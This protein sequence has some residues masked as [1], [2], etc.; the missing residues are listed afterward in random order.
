ESSQGPKPRLPGGKAISPPASPP[1][2]ASWGMD[3]SWGQPSSPTPCSAEPLE[4]TVVWDPTETSTLLLPPRGPGGLG[5]AVN[6]IL[7][8]GKK[9]ERKKEQPVGSSERPGNEA[10]QMVSE[11]TGRTAGK[12]S[13]MKQLPAVTCCHP[14]PSS[15][16]PAASHTLPKSMAGSLLSSLPWRERARAEQARLLTLRGIMGTSSL[17]PTSEERNCPSNT[18]P[19]KC[20]WRKGG[21]GVATTGPLLEELY[22]RNPLVRDI[23]SEC[24]VASGD[25]HLP[26]P[27]AMCPHVSLGSVLSLEL[28]RD[29]V[30]LGNHQEVV[31]QQEEVEGQE[32]LQGSGVRAW[33]LTGTHR[34]RWHE[35][36]YVDGHSAWQRSKKLG[37]VSKC[38]KGMWSQ[39]AGLDPSD[40]QQR[41]HR[42][43]EEHC[44]PLIPGSAGE[45]LVDMRPR[46]LSR[47]CVLHRQ[48]SQDRDKLATHQDQGNSPV[49]PVRAT[50]HKAAPLGMGLSPVSTPSREGAI[51]VTAHTQPP[52]G[53]SQ[54]GE[55]SATAT[56]PT[57]LS[58]FE[59]ALGSP[60]TPSPAAA[61]GE[62]CPP[63]HGQFEEEEEELQAIWD[64]AGGGREPS[65]WEDSRTSCE[66]GSRTGSL[67]SPDAPPATSG[68]LILSSVN[69]VLVA[70]FTLPS[71]ARLLHSQSGEKSPSMGHSSCD[72]PAGGHRVSARGGK[73]VS[74]A[75]LDSPSA[76]D[77]QRNGEERESSKMSPGKIEFQRMEGMLERKHLLQAG[78]RK[79]SCRAWGL[80]HTVLMRQ[81]LCF[82][83]DHRD[84][85][86]SAVVALPLNLSQAVCTPDVEYT[87]KNN[88]FRLQLRDGSEYLLRAP[89]QPLMN[90]WVSKLQQNSGFPEVD[91]FQAAAQPV[92]STC[93][94]GRKVPS[95]SSIHLQGRHEVMATKS[96]E[97]VVLPYSNAQLQQPLGSQ[98]ALATKTVAA[99]GDCDTHRH[100]KQQWSPRGSPELWDKSCQDD[101]GLVA[102][103]RRSYSFTSATYQKITPVAVPKE[104]AEATGSYSVTLYIGEQVP[105]MPRARCHSFVAQ[106]GSQQNML[107]E[108]TSSPPRPKNKSVFKKFFG[109]E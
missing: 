41:P 99:A 47:V 108:K 15:R 44:S 52:A 48:V 91:Y 12:S 42:T 68:P 69:N 83:Q 24:E 17:Q 72:S 28:P 71:A 57:Q 87:K 25:H 45:D 26:D 77:R 104:P 38:E 84:S 46:Q 67:P 27:K 100:R 2:D 98:D 54:P 51:A 89:S 76:W 105:A 18:W 8:I 60:D 29:T 39:E 6:L 74:A 97:I 7:S 80:F 58:V 21:P 35:E 81:T 96:Q 61:P 102:S 14:A 49:V 106:P 55:S 66:L 94:T 103:K 4:Q 43:A 82:Y 10:L 109:K 11:G 40:I 90:E 101:Y 107:G 33:E 92:E 86:K 56:A 23:D 62:A 53:H 88:C 5:R 13:S 63:A 85:L 16:T 34:A 36:V 70:K 3:Q 73:T 37:M 19:Q 65:L 50:D 59:W 20:S 31:A 78:G 9:G 32:Q 79:A 93:S 95:A 1:S 75:P 30:V 64:Q 22:V